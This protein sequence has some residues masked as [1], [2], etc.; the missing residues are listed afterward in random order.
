M[1]MEANNVAYLAVSGQHVE[2]L[3]QDA[4]PVVHHRSPKI[5]KQ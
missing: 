3:E 4:Q 1:Q 2:I 5:K